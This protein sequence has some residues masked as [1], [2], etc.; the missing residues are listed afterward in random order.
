[1]LETPAASDDE[2]SPLLWKRQ[3]H[4]VD[5]NIFWYFDRRNERRFHVRLMLH[6]KLWRKY[7]FPTVT[8]ARQWRDSRKGAAADG[9][10]FPEQQRDEHKGVPFKDYAEHWTASRRT[11]GLKRSTLHSYDQILGK[12]LLPALGNAPL[13]SIDRAKVRELAIACHQEGLKPKTIHNIVRAIFC[14]FSQ[15]IEDGIVQHNPALKPSMMVQL[16]KKGEHVEVFTHEEEQH[17]LETAKKFWPRDHPFVLTLFRTGARFGEAVALMPEDMNFRDRYMV[18]ERNFTHGHREES[19]KSGRRR[20]VDLAQD[21]VAI[22]KEHWALQ[23]AEAA[24]NGRPNPKWLFSSPEGGI[25]RSNNFRDRVW[26]PL[27]K[28]SELNYRCLHAARHTFATRL[29]MAGANLVYVR[30]QLG[31]SSIQ[32]TVDLYTLW[33]RRA[34]REE[35]LQVDL[36]SSPL[37]Q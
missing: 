27:L 21:L 8:K 1:M 34:E 14:L 19:P 23:Q 30:K 5:D 10:L 35:I 3:L 18:I 9:R 31:H 15:A 11:K 16:L 29:I 32:I 20:E 13:R 28:K 33:I 6:G 26:K 36:L 37:T 17:I 7:G 2:Q 22:L 12:R 24:L 25:I 4:Y